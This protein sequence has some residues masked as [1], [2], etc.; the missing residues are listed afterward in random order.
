[1]RNKYLDLNYLV[2]LEAL[3]VERGPTRAAERLH[4]T[5]PAV[6]NALAELREHFG[7]ALLI[8]RGRGLAL[9]PFA[10]GLLG[11]LQ[12]A[13]AQMRSVIVARPD[14]NPA[15]SG[16]EFGV[17]TCDYIA[18]IFLTKVVRRLAAM[19]S[20]VT[21]VH[22]PAGEP[23]QFGRGQAEV[24]IVPAHGHGSPSRSQCVLFSEPV[25]YIAGTRNRSAACLT[26]E[27]FLSAPRVVP[28]D[29]LVGAF[30][31]EGV[32]GA[33][34]MS[35]PLLAIPACVA[36]T[37]YLAAVP[38]GLADMF[39]KILPLKRVHVYG[40]DRLIS[41]IMH[42]RSETADH[43][44]GRWFIGEMRKAAVELGGDAGEDHE[45]RSRR[46]MPGRV[47]LTLPR[48]TDIERRTT[49]CSAM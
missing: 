2:K 15:S 38:Q 37:D 1:M 35:L 13:L 28:S 21:I 5:Q 26:Q 39:E 18:S 42:W 31:P 3:L 4:L 9:T 24:L 45:A 25:A 19:G 40:G 46:S 10:E 22:V 36:T 6:S 12:A 20:N 17:M 23:E 27:E 11:P 33:P 44:I 41:Y 49:A 14:M 47:P 30:E 32:T 34:A 7:D 16:C 43:S 48:R 29:R 8:R